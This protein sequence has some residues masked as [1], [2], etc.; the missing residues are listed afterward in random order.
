MRSTHIHKIATAAK[1]SFVT[2]YHCFGQSNTFSFTLLSNVCLDA[3]AKRKNIAHQFI[4]FFNFVDFQFLCSI[5]HSAPK[6]LNEHLVLFSFR[7]ISLWT[8][9]IW[10]SIWYQNFSQTSHSHVCTAIFDG[11]RDERRKS[12]ASGSN[13]SRFSREDKKEIFHCV[14]CKIRIRRFPIKFD[15][16]I[17]IRPK[18]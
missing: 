15:C 14:I 2:F 16:I 3:F 9:S 17:K 4:Q 8:N 7:C 13:K 1:Q 12:Q 18:F 5:I 10:R 11:D 6:P